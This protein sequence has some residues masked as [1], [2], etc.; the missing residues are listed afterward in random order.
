[1]LRR[2][3]FSFRLGIFSTLGFFHLFGVLGSGT[4]SGEREEAKAHNQI[5]P[6]ESYLG[7]AV[8]L[9]C[10]FGICTRHAYTE[11]EMAGYHFK[12]LTE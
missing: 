6:P 2:H 12:C 3:K 5:L 9:R 11:C 8:A 4:E 10:K 7:D 1:M